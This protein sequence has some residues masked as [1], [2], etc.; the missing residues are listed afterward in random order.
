MSH[1]APRLATTLIALALTVS[2]VILG[3]T[4]SAPTLPHPVAPFG[5]YT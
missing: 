4:R 3:A 2:G 5:C 1:L